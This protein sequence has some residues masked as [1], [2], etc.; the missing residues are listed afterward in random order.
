[1]N[2]KT[3]LHPQESGEKK[4]LTVAQKRKKTL[5]RRSYL[6]AGLQILFFLLTP[7]L[8]T[9]AFSGVKYIFTQ[10]GTSQPLEPVSFVKTLAALCLLTMVFGRFFCG[11][12]CAFGALGD[13]VQFVS[14]QIQKKLKKKLPAIP[15][16]AKKWL[17]KLPY[18][19][20]TA[21]VVLCAAGVY[22]SLSGYS[23]WDVFSM[24]TSLKFRLSGYALGCILLALI[25][26]GMAW[27][28]RFFCRFLCPMGAVFRLLPIFPWAILRRDRSQCGKGCSACTKNC[29]VELSLGEG[30]NAADCIR[31][32]QCRGICPRGNISTGTQWMDAHVEVVTIVKA[33]IYL[34]AAA[35]L[36][37][38]RFV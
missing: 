25:L 8:F 16:G 4:H 26:V 5:K 31:C 36:G 10:I 14:K 7:S 24:A 35:L 3:L 37:C 15:A 11:Y 1:M 21:I 33:V 30:G 19:I 20:L 28:P 13:G 6:R 29:P 2:I 22:G 9:G 23:P 17:S 38:L 27:E 18:G 12:V 32:E 34:A